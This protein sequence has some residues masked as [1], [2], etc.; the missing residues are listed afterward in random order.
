MNFNELKEP[1][2]KKIEEDTEIL[3]LHGGFETLKSF[4]IKIEKQVKDQM[5]TIKK[6]QRFTLKRL[7]GRKFWTSLGSD[8]YLHLAGRCFADMVYKGKFPFI[9]FVVHTG[10]VKKYEFI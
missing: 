8:K 3:V 1:F 2:S 4:Y 7:C 6:G 9:K 5:H 10:S